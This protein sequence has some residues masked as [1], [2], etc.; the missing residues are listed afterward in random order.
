MKAKY[1]LEEDNFFFCI[2]SSSNFLRLRR[3]QSYYVFFTIFKKIIT[4]VMI[5]EK[6]V[7]K[8]CFKRIGA[9]KPKHYFYVLSKMPQTIFSKKL[10]I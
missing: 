3:K 5:E 9:K 8:T 1:L 10:H 2:F 7:G 4:F 6:S